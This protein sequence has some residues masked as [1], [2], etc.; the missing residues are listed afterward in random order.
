MGRPR[1][2]Q[3]MVKSVRVSDHLKDLDL[4]K[5]I[6][7]IEDDYNTLRDIDYFL[8]SNDVETQ[9]MGG[10]MEEKVMNRLG[11]NLYKIVMNCVSDKK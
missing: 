8:N 6:K 5:I 3:K 1:T 9:K 2:G 7:V 4:T 10:V 11:Y